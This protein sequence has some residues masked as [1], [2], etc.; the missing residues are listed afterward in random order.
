MARELGLLGD[1]EE[2]GV[3]VIR[4]AEEPTVSL[5][6]ELPAGLGL[7]RKRSI[8]IA[9]V[10]WDGSVDG[11][12]AIAGVLEAVD[13]HAEAND[14]RPPRLSV[15][16]SEGVMTASVGDFIIEGVKGEVYPCKPDVFAAVYGQAGPEAAVLLLP[17]AGPFTAEGGLVLF[18]ELGIVADVVEGL[19]RA[20]GWGKIQHMDRPQARWAIWEAWVGRVAQG[21]GSAE[22]ACEAMN[23]CL[24]CAG[25]QCFA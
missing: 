17:F 24:G 10:Q 19:V 11:G 13:L 20:R 4:S 6:V 23:A 7:Y 21:A 22:E 3:V 8:V 18:R 2:D 14:P 15:A 5:A 16:T 25:C 1:V 12:E 9:A